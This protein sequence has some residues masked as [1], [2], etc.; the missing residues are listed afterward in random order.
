MKERYSRL[1]CGPI[2][3]LATD[4]YEWEGHKLHNRRISV[5]RH[6]TEDH[7]QIVMTRLAEP[8]EE[9]KVVITSFTIS[10]EAAQSLG[11]LLGL[12]LQKKQE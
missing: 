6:K 1:Y 12:S 8:S 11:F 10:L 2:A 7:L 5:G 9:S 4:D 3:D